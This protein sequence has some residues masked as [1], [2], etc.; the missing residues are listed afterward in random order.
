MNGRVICLLCGE[1]GTFDAP[2][3]WE[4]WGFSFLSVPFPAHAD[5][6]ENHRADRIK[7]QEEMREEEMAR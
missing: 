7:E 1:P 3:R 4:T 2:L 5:C 6:A